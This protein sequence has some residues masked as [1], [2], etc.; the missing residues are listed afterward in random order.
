MFSLSLQREVY[1]EMRSL[2]L[3]R[4]YA[5]R[6]VNNDSRTPQR[7]RGTTPMRHH[8]PNLKWTGLRAGLILALAATSAAA[9]RASPPIA[10][11]VQEPAGIR[12]FQYPVAVE[13]NLPQAL[14]RDTR[15][16]LSRAGKSVLAQVQPAEAGPAAARWWLDFPVDLLPYE[17][18]EYELQPS[19]G[20]P[21][22]PARKPGLK[23]IRSAGEFRVVNDPHI[24]WTVRHDLGGLLKSVRAH[25]LEYVRDDSPGLLLRDGRGAEH[26]LGGRGPSVS[27]TR[28]GAL[29]VGLRFEFREISGFGPD[30]RSTVDLTFPLFK[31][32][33]EVDW[34]LD[35]PRG[36]VAGAEARLDVNLD[37]SA[38][39]APTLVDFGTTGLVYLSL[40]SGQQAQ[41]LG[42]PGPWQVLRGLPDR[43]EP[44]VA[45]PRQPGLSASPE[46]WAHVMDRRRCLA[47]AVDHFSVA[48]ADRFGVSAAGLFELR[49]SFSAA[50]A[51][52]SAAKRLRF[53]LHFIPFPPQ[54]TAATSPQA[55]QNPVVARVR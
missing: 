5:S 44:Y 3:D 50:P 30:V 43:L 20:A 41:L 31:S 55:M 54:E 2:F 39:Q 33:V 6:F 16:R 36:E 48:G 17:S 46:G 11:E 21:P 22:A 42:G 49:R 29:A 23:L 13:L 19:P 37:P 18:A 40:G 14:P 7:L 27:V 15:F 26:A 9:L 38:R 12:R 52:S 47:L 4:Y 28:E 24:A 53:W 45:G 10:I 1:R 35:D 51:S 25:E 34:R 32:W 8:L